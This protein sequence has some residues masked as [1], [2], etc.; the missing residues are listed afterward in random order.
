MR[1]GR[2]SWLP[3]ILAGAACLSAPAEAGGRRGRRG[4]AR[5]PTTTGRFLSD[6]ALQAAIAATPS[7]GTATLPAGSFRGALVVDRPMTVVG[8]PRGT[9]IDGQGTGQPAIRVLAGVRDVAIVSVRVQNVG[10]DGILAEGGNDNLEVRGASVAA[11]AGDGVRIL[12]SADVTVDRC[13]LDGN[14]GDGLDADGPRLLASRLLVRGN[15]GAGAVLRGERA[16]VLDGTFEGGAEGVRFGGLRGEVVR[17]S[18]DDATV[19]IRFA[20]ASDTCSFAHNTVRGGTSAVVAD[21][22]SIYGSVTANRLSNFAGDAIVLSGSWHTVAA[23]TFSSVAGAAVVGEGGS[24]RVQGNDIRGA[25]DGGILLEGS[26]NTVDA[27]RLASVSGPAVA[28]LGAGNV[29]A[30]NVVTGP[31]GDGVVLTGSMNRAVSNEVT[32]AFGEG[33]LLSGDGNTLQGNV[34]KRAGGNGIRIASG[35]RNY[36]VANTVV[37]CGD[38]GVSDEGSGTTLER[39]RVE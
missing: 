19:A 5:T 16:R 39:N 6:E 15:R 4:P 12:A 32:G 20:D 2:L 37:G 17:C 7:G 24:L 13:A 22:G 31:R 35:E 8:A 18:F 26:G 21:V 28:L 33:I 10:A 36:L 23:N 29:V 27:N 9:V 11:C 1:F 25:G 34:L 14:G 38:R 3:L 30:L